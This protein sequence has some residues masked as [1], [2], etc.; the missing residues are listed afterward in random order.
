MSPRH[1]LA[2]LALA[3]AGC[4][5]SAAHRSGA[6]SA[7]AAIRAVVLRSYHPKDVGDCERVFT[8][9]FIQ[10]TFNGLAA[11]QE[12]VR[13]VAK[14]PPRTVSIIAITRHGP[15]ADARI[16][17]DSYDETVKLVQTR[18]RWLVDDNVG[19]DGSAK[20]NVSQSRAQALAREQAETPR[21]LGT[22]ASFRPIS[23][24]GP[25]ASFTVAV[26]RV[27]SHGRT[28][29]GQRSFR[30][31]LTNDFGAV[32][33]R[34]ARYRIV[35]VQVVLTNSGPA[36]FRGTFAGSLIARGRPWPALPHVG[37]RPDGTDGLTHGIAPGHRVSAWLTFGLPA[38]AHITAI[39]VQPEA[40]AGANTVAAVEPDRARWLP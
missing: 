11:C 40:L 39:E 18:G 13:E 32:T 28:R 9:S 31:P 25:N 23:G 33:K 27:V 26:T 3:V 5:A 38:R 2:V 12:H 6:P 10:L 24:A 19:A 34:H 8:P 36:R 21:P 15:V 1:A 17:V 22:A 20:Q 35:N 16:R 4:G 37:R 30:G 29:Q 7:D 14:L